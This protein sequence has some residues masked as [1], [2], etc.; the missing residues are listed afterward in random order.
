M[1]LKQGLDS[2]ILIESSKSHVS[3]AK[4][5]KQWVDVCKETEN[6]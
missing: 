5:N 4:S 2:G 1:I 3:I 6:W